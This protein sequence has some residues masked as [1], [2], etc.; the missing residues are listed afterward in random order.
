MKNSLN[1]QIFK[2][3]N[4][5]DYDK[6]PLI[7]KNYDPFLGS[8]MPLL[9]ILFCSSVFLFEKNFIVYFCIL[10]FII[11]LSINFY[12]YFNFFNKYEIKIYKN[13]IDF[14]KN[15]IVKSSYKL[16]KNR[17]KD[18]FRIKELKD[19][20][21]FLLMAFFILIIDFKEPLYSLIPIFSILSVYTY[22]NLL[23][24]IIYYKNN[25]TFKN[26]WKFRRVMNIAIDFY[27]IGEVFY[28]FGKGVWFK[29]F[30]YNDYKS[31]RMY[32]LMNFGFDIDKK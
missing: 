31:L 32:F 11:I 13:E 12:F 20:Y 10:F 25:K 21:L 22:Q 18:D 5:R 27:D 8:Q 14:L 24:F 7:L 17:V 9:F 4:Q 29:I 1:S 16:D 30:S 23:F 3:N 26:F 15:D 6:E 28:H 2:Q 19:K